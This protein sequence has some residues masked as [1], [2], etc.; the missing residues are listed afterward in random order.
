MAA[1]NVLIELNLACHEEDCV[2]VSESLALQEANNIQID[3]VHN[4]FSVIDSINTDEILKTAK[5]ISSKKK[6]MAI[7]VVGDIAAVPHDRELLGDM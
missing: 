6:S 2:K 1:H 4:S 7:A 5:A 3:S